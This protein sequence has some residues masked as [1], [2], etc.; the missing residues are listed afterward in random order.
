MAVLAALVFFVGKTLVV[1][2]HVA[3][4][5]PATAFTAVPVTAARPRVNPHDSDRCPATRSLEGSDTLRE[6]AEGGADVELSTGSGHAECAARIHIEVRAAL[7]QVARA[8][9]VL[10][11]AERGDSGTTMGQMK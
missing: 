4:L 6:I 11:G 8:L 10:V 5:R 2:V 1:G 7:G 9:S 3:P